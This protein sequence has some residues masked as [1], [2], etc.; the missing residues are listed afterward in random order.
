MIKSKVKNIGNRPGKQVVQV[1]VK[2]P[3]NENFIKVEKE[4]L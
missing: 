4:L 3:Q 2:K 1:Y